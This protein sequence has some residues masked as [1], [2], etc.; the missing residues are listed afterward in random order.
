LIRG[1]IGAEAEG[2][3]SIAL[4]EASFSLLSKAFFDEMER[5]FA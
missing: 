4:S 5:K 3:R 2:R 1:Q